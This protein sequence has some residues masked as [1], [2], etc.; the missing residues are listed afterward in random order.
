MIAYVIESLCLFLYGFIQDRCEI[1]DLRKRERIG[2]M[3]VN[4][5]EKKMVS[6]P[7]AITFFQHIIAERYCSVYQQHQLIILF[8]F[9]INKA[10]LTAIIA[11]NA[12]KKKEIERTV[13]EAKFAHPRNLQSINKSQAR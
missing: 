3:Y 9:Q 4:D 13:G 2:K 5:L 11:F 1:V 7:Q 6:W 8:S 12:N 10:I